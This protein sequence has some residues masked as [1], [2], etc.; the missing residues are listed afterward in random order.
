MLK[1]D[2]R[3]ASIILI[4]FS[5]TIIIFRLQLFLVRHIDI[6]EFAH[7]H[8]TWLLIN[9]F[10][11]YKDFFLNYPGVYQWYLLP[12]FLLPP[13]SIIPLV[14][15]YWEFILYFGTGIVLFLLTKKITKDNLISLLCITIFLIFPMTFD[16]SIDVRPD[17]LM[18]L[19]YLLSVWILWKNNLSN[20]SLL[21]SGFFYGLS[22]MVFTKIVF[23][24]PAVLYL[25]FISKGRNFIQKL[26]WFSLGLFVSPFIF[27][28]YL[29]SQGIVKEG[30]QAVVFDIFIVNQG[31]QAFSPLLALSPWPLV[32]IDREGMSF[33]WLINT[34][35]WISAFF[36]LI[37]LWFLDKKSAMFLTIFFISAIGFLFAFPAPYLQYFLP[38]SVMGS[39][40]SAVCFIWIINLFNRVIKLRF[41][42]YSLFVIT[43]CFSF[44]LS[45][46]QQYSLR[47]FPKGAINTEQ[48]KVIDNILKISKP[49]E[50]FHDMVGS[51]IFR[52]DGYYICCHPYGEFRQNMRVQPQSLM[53]SFKTK[54][55][56]FVV[57]DRNAMVFWQTPEPEKSW[58]Y[59]NFLPS[60]YW[61]IY[62]LG[63]QYKCENGICTQYDFDNRSI[64]NPG[65]NNFEIIV[66]EK[67]TLTLDPPDSQI[68]I[69]NQP[70]TAGSYE[71]KAGL[72]TI[73]VPENLKGWKYQLER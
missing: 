59:A 57:M 61:K 55:T 65:I 46:F 30:I 10:K 35:I 7:L 3:L 36:G 38:L 16:K 2:K 70:Y 60:K 69:N 24:G 71:F 54:Q 17:I 25:L 51:Y 48:L 22:V 44:F 19:L 64:S 32:Y 39:L 56:K 20:K 13:S 23:A 37:K 34:I 4:V 5:V 28:L 67:Y 18:V 50:T 58:L 52:P 62:T 63:R 42:V 49:N 73:L 9:G 40:L 14:A 27:I 6:D 41:F 8:W 47:A 53:D 45:F 29:I 15:R 31:K 12:V 21:L 11:P 26:R 72:Y 1:L 33:P 68:V 43:L 66:G